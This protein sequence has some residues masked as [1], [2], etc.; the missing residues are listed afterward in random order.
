MKHKILLYL[1]M[2]SF[3]IHGVVFANE[4][5]ISIKQCAKIQNDLKRLACFDKAAKYLNKDIVIKKVTTDSDLNSGVNATDTI[6]A[7][8]SEKALPTGAAKNND[9]SDFG[10]RKNTAKKELEEI[11]SRIDGEFKGWSGK[12]IFKLQN[13]QIWKQKGQEKVY[14]RS[15]N[16][17]VTIFRGVFGGFRL[18]VEGVNAR[19]YVKRIK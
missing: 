1:I 7:L 6:P 11:H 3:L 5:I 8:A 13:G 9:E 12:T 19:V 10:L 14:H 15:M 2:I 16:P 17:E 18:K 4:D